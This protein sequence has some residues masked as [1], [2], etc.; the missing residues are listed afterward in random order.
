MAIQRKVGVDHLYFEEPTKIAL[1][2]H[3]QRVHGVP[4][5]AT[6]SE[7]EL[8]GVHHAEHRRQNK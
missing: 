7:W 2:I 4:A 5:P 3:L 8:R 6:K 1:I